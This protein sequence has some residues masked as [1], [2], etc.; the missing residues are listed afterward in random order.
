MEVILTKGS[1]I[2]QGKSTFSSELMLNQRFFKKS[3]ICITFQE[4]KKLV[5]YLDNQVVNTKGQRFTEVKKDDSE[6]MKK[7]Y[8]NLKPARKYRFH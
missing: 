6:E 2:D 3:K 5:R 7:T 4:P 8:I 1:N